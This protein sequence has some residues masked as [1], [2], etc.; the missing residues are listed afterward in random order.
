VP[1]IFDEVAEDLRAERLRTL[2]VRYG[3]ALAVAA[4]VV[5][6]GVGGWQFWKY[7]RAQS[8]ASVAAVFLKAMHDVDVVAPGGQVP[9]SVRAQAE[10]DFAKV[11]AEGDEGYRTLAR[12]REAGLK[13]DDGDLK[14]AGA[15]WDQVAGDGAADPLLRQLASLLWVQHQVDTGDPALI[16][17]RLKPLIAPDSAW[18]ALA[19]EQQAL[20]DIRTGAKDKAR[21]TLK[22]LAGDVTAPEGVRGRA[23]GLLARLG[24]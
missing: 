15:L 2:L 8:T 9:A 5:V 19:L 18:R 11:A 12:L 17:A 13:A 16:E 20:L 3:G 7:H 23:N 10:K 14:S 6:L 21:E 24:T 1:D 4:L 22:Q